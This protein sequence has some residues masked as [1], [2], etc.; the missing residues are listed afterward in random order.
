MQWHIASP[1]ELETVFAKALEAIATLD[2]ID[3]VCVPDLARRSQDNDQLLQLQETLLDHCLDGDRF[4]IL[5]AP[6]ASLADVQQHQQQLSSHRGS[7]NSALYFPW[8]RVQRLDPN[9]PALIPPVVILLASMP[10]A[11]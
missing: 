3:L 5:D 10:R 7:H 8:I 2:T 1:I 6:N 9:L 11:I 4:A